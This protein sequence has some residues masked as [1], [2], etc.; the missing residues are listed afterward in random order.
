MGRLSQYIAKCKKSNRLENSIYY[1]H[2][3][4]KEF[5]YITVYVATMAEKKREW[6]GAGK[7]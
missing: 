3:F 4:V 2:I 7:K 5:S 1:D 6:M